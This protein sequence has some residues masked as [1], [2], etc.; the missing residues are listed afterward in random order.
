MSTDD[1][2]LAFVD[3]IKRVG[4]DAEKGENLHVCCDEIDKII[5]EANDAFS[6]NGRAYA[7]EA[8]NDLFRKLLWDSRTGNTPYRHVMHYS[9]EHIKRKSDELTS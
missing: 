4:L 5:S 3:R 9:I 1:M 6:E 7:L 8:L 2:V